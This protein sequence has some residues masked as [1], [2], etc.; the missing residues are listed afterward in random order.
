M[1]SARHVLLSMQRG[2]S[3]TYPAPILTI[4]ET[5]QVNRYAHAYF[6]EKFLNFCAGR[7]PCP[8]TADFG[9]VDSWV[10]AIELQ[11]KRHNFRNHVG[12]SRHP[13]DVPVPFV[14]EFCWGC[15]VWAL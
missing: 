8:K 3:A 1:V 14:R 4:F 10:L 7:F 2:L 13:K 12:A 11:V 15:T 9:T 5:T 6:C